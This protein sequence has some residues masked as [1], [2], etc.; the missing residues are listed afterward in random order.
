MSTYYSR[1]IVQYKDGSKASG[2]KVSMGFSGGF[3]KNFFTDRNGV[4][5]I[6]HASR[7]RAS[8]YVRGSNKGSFQAPGEFVAFI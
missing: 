2:A 4:A 6:A 5:T 8:V 7:G 1:I 3:T